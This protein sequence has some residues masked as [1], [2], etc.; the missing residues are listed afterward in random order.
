MKKNK[1]TFDELLEEACKIYVDNEYKESL[2]KE[3][4]NEGDI[5]ENEE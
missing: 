3:R 2:E 5:E 4:Q 1:K